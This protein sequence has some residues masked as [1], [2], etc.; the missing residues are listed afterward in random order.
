[1]VKA[2]GTK[3]MD[4]VPNPTLQ[5]ADFRHPRN[6]SILFSPLLS[7]PTPVCL[8]LELWYACI[9]KINEQ[10]PSPTSGGRQLADMHRTNGSF[11]ILVRHS[12]VGQ[13]DGKAYENNKYQIQHRRAKRGLPICIESLDPFLI[14]VSFHT[15]MLG[16][17]MLE[18]TI[19]I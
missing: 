6:F 3:R 15:P 4:R 2:Y 9:V 19:G 17:R 8:R 12:R 10:A 16:F 11:L 18:K 14:L 7:F 5:Q 13:R 1:M